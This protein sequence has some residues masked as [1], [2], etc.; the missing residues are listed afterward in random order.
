MIKWLMVIVGIVGNNNK[1]LRFLLELF[2]GEMGKVVDA[3]KNI[4]NEGVQNTEKISAHIAANLS[5]TAAELIEEIKAKYG[6]ELTERDITE[7]I[8]ERKM[9][10]YIYANQ[11]KEPA[12]MITG[13]FETYGIEVTEFELLRVA[14]EKGY[15]KF[16]LAKNIILRRLKEEGKEKISVQSIDTMIQNAVTRF[17]G[18]K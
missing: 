18:K 13:I 2:N 5:K 11:D 7:I 4:I 16:E 6:Y 3:A 10:E 12:G 17:F 14:I 15:S 8:K 9:R 1:Y